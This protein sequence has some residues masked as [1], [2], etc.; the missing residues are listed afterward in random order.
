[1]TIEC[2]HTTFRARAF[3]EADVRASGRFSAEEVRTILAN[4]GTRDL[5]QI[6]CPDWLFDRMLERRAASLGMDLSLYTRR[7]P[8]PALSRDEQAAAAAQLAALKSL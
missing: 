6:G 5:R 3:N 1:M 4:S 7:E 8:V 2:A